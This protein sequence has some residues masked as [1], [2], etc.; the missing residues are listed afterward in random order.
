MKSHPDLDPLVWFVRDLKHNRACKEVQGHRCY[1]RHM[2][3]TWRKQILDNS[4]DNFQ[5]YF[6][7]HS[8]HNHELIWHTVDIVDSKLVK[9]DVQSSIENVHEVNQLNKNTKEAIPNETTHL[10]CRAIC[11]KQVEP[12]DVSE[13]D[14]NTFKVISRLLKLTR[15]WTKYGMVCCKSPFYSLCL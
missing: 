7:W 6:L 1:F 3:F 10:C 9:S 14:C 11:C 15:R 8:W 13:E 12:N 2:L 5:T 4:Q